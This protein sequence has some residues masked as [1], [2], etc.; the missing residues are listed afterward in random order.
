VSACPKCGHE[1]RP[2]ARF[3]DTCGSPLATEPVRAGR[4][5]RKTVTVLFADLVGFTSQAEELDPEDVRRLLQPYYARLRQELE[6]HGGTVEKFIGD[7]VMALFGAPLAH[8][9]DPERAV[10]A[11]LAIR[12]AIAEADSPLQVRIAVNTGE[13]LIA[14][15]ARPAEGEGMASGD[16]VNTAARIQT[17][18]PVNGVLVGESTYRATNQSIEYRDAEPIQAKG[19]VE[20]VPVWEAVS[21]RSRFGLD[22]EQRPRT[23]MVGR[24]REL[25]FLTD[26]LERARREGEPQL[27]T[28]VGVPGIGKSRLVAEL[29]QVV[30]RDPDLIWWRQGR[31]LPYGDGL[32]Y[33]ALAEIV[34]AQAGIA[35]TDS[36][37]DAGAKLRATIESV[38]SDPA[39]AD[40]VESHLRPLVGLSTAAGGGEDT[41]TEAY[42]A[43]RR[44]LEA[45]AEQRTLVLVFEDLHWADD[46]LLDFIDYL[47]D[48]ASA[49]PLLVVCMARP[50]LLDRRPGWGG[51]KRNASTATIGAL[52]PEDTA[53]L[54]AD[55]LEQTLLPAEIHRVVLQRAEGNPLYAEEYVRMLRDRGLL[56]RGESGWHF[57]D[58]GDLPL[59]ESVQGMIAARLDALPPEEKQLVQDAAVVGKVFWPGA[60]AAL[61]QDRDAAAVERGL[62]ALE[63]KEF[64][65]RERASVVAG[66][67]QFA[68]L[69]VLV[70]DVAYAQIPRS[71]R[72]DKHRQAA[73]W[74]ASLGSDRSEDRAEMLAHHYLQALE[75]AEAAGDDTAA[76]AGP[77]SQALMEA[78]E[79]AMALNSPT[80]GLRYSR[81]ALELLPADHPA[82]AEVL[83]RCAVAGWLTGE[84]GTDAAEQAIEAA[85][86]IGDLELAAEATDTLASTFWVQ[87]DHDRSLEAGARA[88]GLVEDRPDSPA[89]ARVMGSYGRIMSLAGNIQE[90][91]AV[92]RSAL[93]AAEELGL[94]DAASK[95]L[96]TIGMVRGNGGDLE[97]LIDLERSVELALRTSSPDIIH[98][99]YNNIANVQFTLGRFE[100][101]M[102]NFRLARV[103]AERFGNRRALRWLD[104]EDILTLEILGRWDEALPLADAFIAETEKAPFY[105]ECP[106]RQVRSWIRLGRGDVQGALEDADR[107]LE[108]ARELKD[109]QVLDPAYVTRARALLEADRRADADAAL[110]EFMAAGAHLGDAWSRG[111]GLL[112][113]RM[114]RAEE[115]LEAAKTGSPTP[116]LHA[117]V[118][119]AFGRFEEAIRIYA[120]MGARADEARVRLAAAEAAAAEGRRGDAERHVALAL[121]FYRSVGAVAYARRAESLLAS[122]A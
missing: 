71:P 70:R 73:E 80:A 114:G 3:C 68:F 81:K 116:W 52:S 102:E 113:L 65:R 115:F 59:P 14:L 58:E 21:A 121:E 54:L 51:G 99:A 27:V 48:W 95:A 84:L 106:V 93:R 31:S 69:H 55:L 23:P 47:V 56:Q 40:W 89:K 105:L 122:S 4:E 112:M 103:A 87:G 46:G 26:A 43:W 38:L 57:S 90:G 72:A 104:G 24:R 101:G 41:R 74:I 83:H 11:A 85:L 109:P 10:R 110:D 13:A 19:K 61:S 15:G 107:A 79:R 42:S 17:A 94:D 49:V 92:S 64:V 29:Y 76:L 118:A 82:R 30:D 37:E 39:E 34:K 25:G 2:E 18:A 16:V 108:L 77:A 78:G 88:V 62:H 97:G 119:E 66:E 63:R 5:E 44:F 32:S 96:N 100:D 36:E 60:L 1:N 7:A 91:L 53:R 33:W 28:L 111:I 8:E 75:L 86:R 12:D 117:G 98:T 50:E 45:L 22:V 9:D 6:R 67:R 120:E 35:E 20:P